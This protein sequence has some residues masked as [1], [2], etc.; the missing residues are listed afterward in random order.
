MTTLFNKYDNVF[1]DIFKQTEKIE[2]N[3]NLT[4]KIE[5]MPEP[6]EYR[7]STM[8][9]ITTFGCNINLDVVD[10]YFTTDN[11]IISMDYGHKPVKSSSIKKRKNKRPFFNQATMIVKLDPLKKINVKIFSNGKIQMTGVKKESDCRL[12]LNIIIQKLE[13]TEGKIN[14]KKLL[15]SHQIKILQKY[16]NREDRPLSKYYYN[17]DNKTELLVLDPKKIY[18]HLISVIYLKKTQV[19]KL[20]LPLEFYK[21][22]V[23]LNKHNEDY[24]YYDLDIDKL[25]D[26]LDEDDINYMAYSIEEKQKI[27]IGSIETVLINSDFNVN[28]KIKR[29]ILHSILKDDYQIV[30]RFEPGIYPGVNNKYYYNTDYLDK[31]YPG[32]CYCTKRCEG[33]GTGQGNGQCKKITIAAFQSGSIIITGARE[34]NH[35]IAAKEFIIT[36]VLKG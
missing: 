22:I 8:T 2:S 30:S 26:S 32:R 29:N 25:Y 33:K 1:N 36:N 15:H 21:K 9:M 35:I 19:Y 13:K 18:D 14:I 4:E 24:F 5:S 3:I 20:P 17:K 28:F 12:A 6:S 27:N 16:L 34:I 10:K 23:V 31:Q 11:I 7:I